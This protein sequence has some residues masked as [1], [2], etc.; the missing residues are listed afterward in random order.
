VLTLEQQAKYKQLSDA[1]MKAMEM[2]KETPNQ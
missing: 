2:K 1:K